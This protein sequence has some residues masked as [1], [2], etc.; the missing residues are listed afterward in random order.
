MA[1]NDAF[2]A[3]GMPSRTGLQ[4]QGVRARGMETSGEED[5]RWSR[6]DVVHW[7]ALLPAIYTAL[8]AALGV[9]VSGLVTLPSLARD[10]LRDVLADTLQLIGTSVTGWIIQN[11]IEYAPM[12]GEGGVAPS[13]A[14]RCA[15]SALAS[16]GDSIFVHA[17]V[18]HVD[19][20]RNVRGFNMPRDSMCARHWKHGCQ[21]H[22]NRHD[23]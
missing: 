9:V 21:P 10:E 6:N 20:R 1:G 12:R 22:A 16:Q 2:V 14:T 18:A 11:T 5:K 19:Q 3:E 13:W 4:E 17:I 8:V 23:T 7:Q 15:P